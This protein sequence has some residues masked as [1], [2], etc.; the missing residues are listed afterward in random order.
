MLGKGTWT[1][2]VTNQGAQAPVGGQV[3]SRPNGNIQA[4]LSAKVDYYRATLSA[5]SGK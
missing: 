3:L 1:A 4:T 2:T 5:A